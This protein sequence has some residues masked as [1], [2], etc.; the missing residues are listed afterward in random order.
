ME[1]HRPGTRTIGII[2]ETSGIEP[3]WHW[4]SGLVGKGQQKLLGKEC[5]RDSLFVGL[6]PVSV[7]DEPHS[8][9]SSYSGFLVSDALPAFVDQY[10]RSG[11]EPKDVMRED[12]FGQAG[13]AMTP[14]LRKAYIKK[15]GFKDLYDNYGVSEPLT[16]AFECYVHN[17]W[18]V[19]ADYY[20]IELIDPDTGE[21]LQPGERGELVIT[22][23]CMKAIPWIRY[24]TEDFAWWT[25]EE[26]ECG[27]T[28]P[29]MV[30]YDRTV[31]RVRIRDKTVIPYDVREIME[32]HPETVEA[33]FNIIKYAEVMDTL[34]LRASYN[35][36][37][38]RDADE[39]KGR[40]VRDFEESFGVDAEIEWVTFDE[41][42]KM[43]HKLMRVVD[44]TKKAK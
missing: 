9:M 42:A 33:N 25:E 17:G 8:R 15:F 27:R 6:L 3:F 24:A 41:L 29:R 14:Y 31:F 13:E 10:A 28:H 23:L 18:H 36:A 2:T 30:V 34:R 7:F 21:Q 11:I 19:W 5:V 40:L 44:M 26:C 35:P 4:A 32:R 38:T 37:L 1:K 22:N 16:G 20:Y 12:Y 39:L 43:L